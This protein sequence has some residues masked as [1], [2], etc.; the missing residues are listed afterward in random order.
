MAIDVGSDSEE[1]GKTNWTI[2]FEG[3]EAADPS[4]SVAILQT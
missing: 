1:L 4:E 3:L 2:D